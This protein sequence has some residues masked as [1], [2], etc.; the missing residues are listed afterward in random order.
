MEDKDILNVNSVIALDIDSKKVLLR[1]EYGG[2]NGLTALQIID[3]LYYRKGIKG[4][5]YEDLI[6]NE[7]VLRIK[8]RKSQSEL[9]FRLAI[10]PEFADVTVELNSYISNRVLT[11]DEARFVCQNKYL[12]T[13]NELIFVSD[14]SISFSI[15]V[16]KNIG[17]QNTLPLSFALYLFSIRNVCRYI[18][19]DNDQI[20]LKALLKSDLYSSESKLFLQE[21]YSYQKDGL[22]WLKY[23]IINRVGGILGDDM[24]L[25][26]TAQIIALISWAIEK[27]VLKNILIVVPTTLLENWRREFDF[28][29]PALKPYL[30]HGGNRSGSIELLL[31]QSIVITSYSMIINDLYLF[32]KLNWGCII[33]DEAGAIKNPNSERKKALSSLDAEV[34]I[35]MSGTPVE[36]SL[37]DVWSICDFVMPG[38]L[39]TIEAF[40]NKYIRGSV[41]RTVLESDLEGLKKDLSFI[42][43][44]RKKE[45]VLDSLPEKI[46]IHQA[47]KMTEYEAKLYDSERE[48]ILSKLGSEN[49]GDILL[50]IQNMRQYTTHPL[51]LRPEELQQSNCEDLC[52]R[53]TKFSRTIELLDEIR[54][55]NE[56]VILFTEYLQMIDAMK[57]VLTDRYGVKIESI[58][59][60]VNTKL[61]QKKIDDFS[62][63]EG[64]GV[65]VLNPKTAGVGLNITSANHVIHY[66]RQW[67]PA[68][69][70]QATARSYRNKQT[71]NVNVYYLYYV[72]TIEEVIDD[73]LR[74]K[75]SLSG[76]V[77]ATTQSELS[78]DDYLS[79]LRKTPLV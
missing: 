22:K 50:L 79:T 53:S 63:L 25:G 21:L 78:F 56:K 26:K 2:A 43:L 51:L 48:R 41:E 28:F 74:L 13:S 6:I 49:R 58:D 65:L 32:N 68:L 37:I 67:N 42:M 40:G 8:V 69:E 30:H 34:K 36:N 72:D 10:E 70:E 46:D 24:G 11:I 77:V 20:D 38:F 5:R 39:G 18:K 60:R 27:Q 55:C 7:D 16:L 12:I 64:F 33:V 45:D 44:R 19:F 1:K 3:L 35:A 61:R 57:R 29:A 76:E 4:L 73:R 71:K 47:L 52:Q 75:K 62:C 23:C 17:E 14:D 15:D 59:G 66:T 9:V 54:S 31:R